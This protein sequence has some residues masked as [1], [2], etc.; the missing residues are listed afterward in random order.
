M[1]DAENEKSGG[2]TRAELLRIHAGG[3]ALAAV[4]CLI[5]AS[6]G[7]FAFFTLGLVLET[8]VDPAEAFQWCYLAA[9]AAT[10]FPGS[11]LMRIAL[12]DSAERLHVV[13]GPGDG[14]ARKD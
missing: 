13:I 3:Y 14:F 1:H 4:L 11:R 8:P 9:L 6:L 2:P 10:F 7:A 12:P 5:H